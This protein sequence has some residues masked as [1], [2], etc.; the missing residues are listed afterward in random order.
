MDLFKEIEEKFGAD[1]ITYSTL[2]K[3]FCTLD[4]RKDGLELLKKMIQNKT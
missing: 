2:I 3:G 1:L 4:R